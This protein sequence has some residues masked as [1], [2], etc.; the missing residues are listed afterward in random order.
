MKNRKI[1]IICI[2]IASFLLTAG[3]VK[4]A[5]LTVDWLKVGSQ[6]TGGV[7]YFNGTI[8]NNTTGTGGADNPVT[9][10]DNVRIDGRVYRGATAG[11]SDTLPFIVNDN[12]EVAGNLTVDGNIAY[13]NSASGLTST[14]VQG[15]IDELGIKLSK[16]VSGG[17][18]AAAGDF[19]KATLSATT[20][21]GTVKYLCDATSDLGQADLTVTFTPITETSGTWTSTPFN[22]FNIVGHPNPVTDGSY[23][24]VENAIFFS[25]SENVSTVDLRGSKMISNNLASGGAGITVLT[26]Q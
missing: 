21:T 15:A 9:F 26:R 1:A 3:I 4:A 22:A 25:G 12:M 7:T 20:W 24:I 19:S 13:D 16:L 17:A 23:N 5:G 8:I 2:I 18:L 10:G 14:S 11:T 6:G